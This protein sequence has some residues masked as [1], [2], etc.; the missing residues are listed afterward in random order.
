MAIELTPVVYVA[1]A[2]GLLL[3][4]LVGVLLQ[5]R[6]GRGDRERVENIQ[7]EL[8]ET[9]EELESQREEVAR[10]FQQTS[11]LFRDLTEHYTH[12]Y[13]HLAEGA[14]HFCPDDVP[15]LG[16][17]VEEPLL[18]RDNAAGPAEASDE[19]PPQG[20]DAADEPRPEKTNG[21]SPPPV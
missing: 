13:A 7:G 21:G 12:L 17:G 16:L 20:V 19:A 18:G 9:R 2:A 10:H 14:R 11:S 3:G 4:G 15:A 5:R 8:D 1:L 6:V